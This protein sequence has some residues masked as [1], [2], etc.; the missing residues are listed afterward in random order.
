M[1][2]FL[3]VPF[4]DPSDG[5]F[6][7]VGSRLEGYVPPRL[8][9]A[10]VS[11][12][13]TTALIGWAVIRRFRRP[14]SALHD[15]DRQLL[16]MAGVVLIANSVI[17]FAYTKHEI[18]SVAGAF[19]AFAAFVTARCVIDS[20]HAST[21]LAGAAALMVLAMVATTWTFRTAGVHHML[22]VQAFQVRVDWARL[23][24]DLMRDTGSLEGRV[25]AALVR[26][27]RRDALEA[28]VTN[29]YLLP[30]WADRW[31]GE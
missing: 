5:V 21:R 9:V 23:S 4:A 15:A 13:I 20:W 14:T 30:R 10:V 7:L 6:Q 3:S 19:Y 26:H 16:V 1:T 12:T 28:P 8:Y 22:R 31:L 27:L 2:S 29:R 25:A 17:S 24:P 11:S 18:L